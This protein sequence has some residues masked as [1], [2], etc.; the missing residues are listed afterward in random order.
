M[1]REDLV[2]VIEK[3]GDERRTKISLWLFNSIKR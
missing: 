3:Y 1:I 2:E